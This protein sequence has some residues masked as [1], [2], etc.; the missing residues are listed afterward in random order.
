M[1]RSPLPYT[2][3][4][5]YLSRYLGTQTVEWSNCSR[6]RSTPLQGGL[7][8]NGSYLLG[9]SHV[10]QSVKVRGNYLTFQGNTSYGESPSAHSW[11]K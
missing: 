9:S 5:R 10:T 8:V 6:L 11:A 4:T 2:D 7:I 3:H 1:S